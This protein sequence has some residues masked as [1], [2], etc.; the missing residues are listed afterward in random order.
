M[1][2]VDLNNMATQI[3]TILAGVSGVAAA[4]DYEP[5]ELNQLPATTLYF[6][7]FTGEEITMQRIRYTWRWTIRLY[8]PI[9][10]TDISSPQ[11]SLRTLTTNILMALRANIQ[12]NETALY[13]TV[14]AGNVSYIA[15]Q[16]N[17]MLENEI[18]LEVTTEEN[19]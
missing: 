2:A 3:K 1:A 10:T 11:Q 6:D 14:S 18:T 8:I 7:G 9:N 15:G 13:S 16:T 17:T 5:Q 12:L 4:F 19:R